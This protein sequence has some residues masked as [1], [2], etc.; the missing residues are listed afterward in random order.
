M[1]A[2]V[3]VIPPRRFRG[4]GGKITSRPIDGRGHFVWARFVKEMV[5]EEQ[6]DLRSAFLSHCDDGAFTDCQ[7]S[8]M[9]SH[10]R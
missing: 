3:V 9:N 5:E 1:P 7:H 8:E 6:A 10:I 2:M 4:V